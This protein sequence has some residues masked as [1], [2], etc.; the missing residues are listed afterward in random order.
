MGERWWVA[1]IGN[2]ALV[3]SSRHTHLG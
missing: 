1:G 2:S 3:S